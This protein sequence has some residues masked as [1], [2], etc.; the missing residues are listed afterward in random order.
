MNSVTILMYNYESSLFQSIVYHSF[1]SFI[2]IHSFLREILYLKRSVEYYFATS[3]AH[4]YGLFD[5]EACINE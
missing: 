2:V 1:H 5:Y 3:K 4:L